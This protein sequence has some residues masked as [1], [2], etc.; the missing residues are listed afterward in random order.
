[1]KRSKLILG[2]ALCA[3][4]FIFGCAATAACE[5][6]T[7][8]LKAAPSERLSNAGLYRDAANKVLAD[9]A[10][11]YESK[12]PEWSNGAVKRRFVQL[13]AGARIDSADMDHWSFPVGTRL[14][15]ELTVDGKRVETRMIERTGTEDSDFRFASYMWNEDETDAELTVLGAKNVRGTA[16]DIPSVG[17][18]WGCHTKEKERVL[19]FSAIQLSH[20]GAGLT[21]QGLAAAGRLTTPVADTFKMPGTDV[22]ANALGYL[23]GNCGYCHGE[24][25]PKGLRL[26]VSVGSRNVESTD[27]YESAV[28]VR[29]LRSHM[30]GERRCNAVA[31]LD[32]KQVDSNGIRTVDAWI[33]SLSRNSTFPFSRP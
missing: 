7:S 16:H 20:D 14:W 33:A 29:D 22:A 28:G 4:P 30:T 23:H 12:Y 15:T 1:M 19:G 24:N 8:A 32:L 13:P 9:D 2:L 11:A 18:C 21:V 26:R 3:L 25:G 31:K 10:V 5:A 6:A 27:A 17:A